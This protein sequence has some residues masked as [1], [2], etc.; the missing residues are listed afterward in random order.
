MDGPSRMIEDIYQEL[1]ILREQLRTLTEN[2]RKQDRMIEVVQHSIE[3]LDN[4][5]K[6]EMAEANRSR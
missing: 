5:R 1:Q 6:Y 2:S 4:V 3:T